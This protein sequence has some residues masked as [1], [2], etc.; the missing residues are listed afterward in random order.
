MTDAL[1][2]MSVGAAPRPGPAAAGDNARFDRQARET[3]RSFEA[4]F[5]TRMLEQMSAGIETNG[6]FGGGQ[7][8][9][10][11]RSLLNQQYAENLSAAGGVGLADTI[12]NELIKAQEILNS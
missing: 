12:Y 4:F 9:K 3:A 8:E 5:L 6:P 11:Y 10:I 1:A 2:L 7:S